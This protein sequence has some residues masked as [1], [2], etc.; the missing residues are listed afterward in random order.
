MVRRGELLETDA[1]SEVG[2][3][4]TFLRRGDEVLLNEEAGHLVRTKVRYFAFRM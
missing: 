3:Y 2:V 4:G 1:V